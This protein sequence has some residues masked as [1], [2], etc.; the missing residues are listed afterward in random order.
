MLVLT[1]ITDISVALSTCL[2]QEVVWGSKGLFHGY[3]IS[4]RTFSGFKVGIL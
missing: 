2:G 1:T 4:K 3:H